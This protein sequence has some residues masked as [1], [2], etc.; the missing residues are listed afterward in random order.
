MHLDNL[1]RGYSV[2]LRRTMTA[3][4]STGVY[5]GGLLIGLTTRMFLQK[6]NNLVVQIKTFIT[7]KPRNVNLTE[8]DEEVLLQFAKFC[9][10]NDVSEITIHDINAY[11]EFVRQTRTGYQVMNQNIVIR[12]FLRYYNFH[13]N[14]PKRK[15][16]NPPK[17]EEIKKIK[18]LVDEGRSYRDVK[19]VTGLQLSQIHRWYHFKLPRNS[20]TRPK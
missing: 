9:G 12:C 2:L 5:L 18:R 4:V 1:K 13:R 14:M 3:S 6:K 16:G 17:I 11:S 8:E 10:K 15:G 7:Y 19:E 20:S